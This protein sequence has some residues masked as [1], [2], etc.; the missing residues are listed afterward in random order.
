ME[1]IVKLTLDEANVIKDGLLELPAKKSLAVIQNFDNQ[2]MTQ[3]REQEEKVK[4]ENA[5]KK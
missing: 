3:I 1:F 4:A 5:T 2:I